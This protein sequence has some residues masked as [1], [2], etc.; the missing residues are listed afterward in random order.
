MCS[1]ARPEV[2]V[3]LGCGREKFPELVEDTLMLE[4]DYCHCDSLEISDSGIVNVNQLGLPVYRG[5]ATCSATGCRFYER[6]KFFHRPVENT[7]SGKSPIVAW[8]RKISG[9]N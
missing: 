7:N 4:K 5:M 8:L 1:M 9:G 3:I 2:T 6:G